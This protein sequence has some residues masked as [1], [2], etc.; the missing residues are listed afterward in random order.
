[1]RVVGGDRQDA[2]VIPNPWHRLRDEWPDVKWFSTNL[3]RRRAETRWYGDGR[4]EIHL[5]RDLIQIQR[6]ASLAHELEHLDR[7]APCHTLKASIEQRVLT[8]TARYLLPDLD[9]I[10]DAI[11]VYDLRRAAEE[12]WV[13]FVVLVDRLNGLTDRESRYVHSL[14]RRE[15][16]A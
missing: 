15:Q 14:S 9:A 6:R 11:E 3:G 12:L 8:A 1:M 7:G 5:H 2:H 10:R 16:V 4:V 13:P